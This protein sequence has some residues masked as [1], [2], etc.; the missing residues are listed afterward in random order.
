M[1]K[2][3]KRRKPT[4]VRVPVTSPGDRNWVIQCDGKLDDG[5]RC[6]HEWGMGDVVKLGAVELHFSIDHPKHEG[7]IAFTLEWRGK[8]PKPPTPVENRK[9]RRRKKGK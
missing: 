3:Q 4:T 8:G 9:M 2:Q 1:G 7:P 5:G 6:P